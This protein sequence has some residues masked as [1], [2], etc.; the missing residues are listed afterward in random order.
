MEVPTFQDLFRAV[1]GTAAAVSASIVMEEE[2]L[3]LFVPL[4]QIVDDVELP[5]NSG[6]LQRTERKKESILS[7]LPF[8]VPFKQI[9]KKGRD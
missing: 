5:S 1:D 2:L 4:H 7:G 8:S 6:I 9:V 3:Q